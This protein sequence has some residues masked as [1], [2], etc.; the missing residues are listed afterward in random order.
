MWV[1]VLHR[2]SFSLFSVPEPSQPAC[3]FH[4]FISLIFK[5]L[6]RIP[7]SFPVSYTSIILWGFLTK[8]WCWFQKLILTF[9]LILL[10][11]GDFLSFL[12]YYDYSICIL[13][14][15]IFLPSICI[16]LHY[17]RLFLRICHH[18]C[19]TMLETSCSGHSTFFV[20]HLSLQSITITSVIT[21]GSLFLLHS[22][23]NLWDDYIHSHTF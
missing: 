18:M 1:Y 4:I 19:L 22:Q 7:R 13:C 6:T 9:L 11:C 20:T 14:G 5:T 17:I 10:R 23:F 3:S 2:F 15:F 16:P 12:S 8:Y 21:S